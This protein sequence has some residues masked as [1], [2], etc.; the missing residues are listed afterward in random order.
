MQTAHK[1]EAEI[2]RQ[3]R[4][5]AKIQKDEHRKG[6]IDRQTNKELEKGDRVNRHRRQKKQLIC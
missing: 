6:Q 2:D 1:I 5:K 4:K 3:K